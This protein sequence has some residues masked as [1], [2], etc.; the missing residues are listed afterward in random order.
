M[1]EQT[2]TISKSEYNNL[3]RD[4]KMLCALQ[5]GGVDNWEWYGESLKDFFKEE[6]K[7]ESYQDIYGEEIAR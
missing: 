3:V 5:S 6:E 1:K 4:S 7:T 2:V